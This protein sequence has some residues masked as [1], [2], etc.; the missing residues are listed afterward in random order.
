M[1][2]P[3]SFYSETIADSTVKGNGS[4]E[5][6]TWEVPVTTLTAANYVAQQAL[7]ATLSTAVEAVILGNLAKTTIT[8]DRVLVSGEPAA[9]Q[10]AQRENK[11]LIRYEDA[12]THQKF[13]VS[14]GTFDLT[15]LPLHS[16]FLDIETASTP[17]NDLKLAFE[18]IVKSPDNASNAVIMTS[19]QFVGRNT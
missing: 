16:E 4:P 11:L 14:I 10:L 3:V 5:T 8:I 12:T 17:G 7:I 19:A 6:T 18:A 1:S 13:Q 15:K 2:L 9:T